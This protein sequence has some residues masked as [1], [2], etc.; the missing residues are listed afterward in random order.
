M[1]AGAWRDPELTAASIEPTVAHAFS[2]TDQVT[3]VFADDV[4]LALSMGEHAPTGEEINGRFESTR[5]AGLGFVA[6][7]DALVGAHFEWT[8]AMVGAPELVEKP[9]D[10][11]W[12]T[13]TATLRGLE[14][15][16]SSK[17]LE[18]SKSLPSA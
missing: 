11:T 5:D 3:L 14:N 15:R 1:G 17:R 8:G 4:A 10:D 6:W 16:W 2:D 13:L 12:K 9:T 18:G 7:G